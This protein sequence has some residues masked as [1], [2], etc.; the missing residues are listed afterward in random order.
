[1]SYTIIDVID[2]LIDI[3]INA[4]K[5]YETI[6]INAADN[7][8]LHLVA[9]VLLTEEK[10]HIDYYE[11]IKSHLQNDSSTILDDKS[12]SK[13]ST[14][15]FEFNKMI[16]SLSTKSI[17]EL[18]EYAL[19]MENVNVGLLKQIESDVGNKNYTNN[20]IILEILSEMIKQEEQH[21]KNIGIF[22]KI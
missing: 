11:K 1:M 8:K 5:I 21:V 19:V 10:R 6:S 4:V 12:Y 15:I 17:T 22:I 2:S 18:L 13:I 7:P 14:H 16:K 9:N 20:K 3:E